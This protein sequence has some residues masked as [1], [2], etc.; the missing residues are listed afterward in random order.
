MKMAIRLA[1]ADHPEQ[2][3]F[4]LGA[5]CQVGAP[6]AGVHVADADENGR[7][8]KRPPLLPKAGLMMRHLHGAVH[9]LQGYV[10]GL[11]NFRSHLCLLC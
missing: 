8:D 5:A 9:A 4:E 2:P 10:A 1:S 6:V 3:V 11:W 7:P